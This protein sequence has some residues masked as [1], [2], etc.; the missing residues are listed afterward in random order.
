ML[1]AIEREHREFVADDRFDVYRS[2]PQLFQVHQRFAG[3]IGLEFD[4]REGVLQ[5]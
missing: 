3:I 1:R 4:A 2:T 5:I